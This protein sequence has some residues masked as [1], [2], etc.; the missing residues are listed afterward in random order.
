VPRLDSQGRDLLGK[1][2][3]LNPDYRITPEEAL[4][5]PYF[6]EV[7]DLIKNMT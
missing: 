2:L 3:E 4:E 5:H 7:P 6:E 1:L